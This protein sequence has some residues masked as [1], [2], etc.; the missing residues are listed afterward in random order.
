M[1][2]DFIFCQRNNKLVW[3]ET[4][5]IV[6]ELFDEVWAGKDVISL[7]HVGEITLPVWVYLYLQSS[8]SRINIELVDCPLCDRCRR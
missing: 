4:V 7:D 5:K 3:D 2:G 6:N 8:H 1:I